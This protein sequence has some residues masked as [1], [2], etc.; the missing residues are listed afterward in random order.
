MRKMRPLLPLLVLLGY[1]LLRVDAFFLPRTHVRSVGQSLRRPPKMALLPC[2]PLFSQYSPQ[3]AVVYK[4]SAL[5]EK[6]K[7]FFK[8]LI[9]KIKVF[10]TTALLALLV[11]CAGSRSAFAGPFSEKSN[12]VAQVKVDT[13]SGKASQSAAAAKSS[14][15]DKKID[16][17]VAGKAAKA[18]APVKTAPGKASSKSTAPKG[19]AVVGKPV[20]KGGA[21]EK[22][23]SGGARS[24]L[25]S[26]ADR[27]R[28]AATSPR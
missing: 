8:S 12:S 15:K 4:S 17:K 10:C 7:G 1:V 20:A 28:A 3:K 19:S 18:S 13:R 9:S 25:Q 2:S 6:V 23:S 22:A 27:L 26:L 16:V 21:A 5:V 11:L 24:R 14:G